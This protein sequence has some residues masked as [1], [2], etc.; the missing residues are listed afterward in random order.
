LTVAVCLNCG[1]LKYGSWVP[2]QNCG[3]NPETDED[4]TKSLIVSDHHHSKEELEGISNKIKAG[5]EITFDPETLKNMWIT[6]EQMEQ[7]D[8]S[9]GRFIWGCLALIGVGLSIIAFFWLF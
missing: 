7:M 2:C 6:K 5:E 9:T 1:E 4:V 8:K 3:F